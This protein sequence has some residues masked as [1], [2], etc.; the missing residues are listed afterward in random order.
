MVMRVSCMSRLTLAV[1]AV[2]LLG[3]FFCGVGHAALRGGCAKVNI[4]PPL[5]ITL[6]GSK[7]QPSDS[8]RDDLYARAMVLNDG[9][10]T[11]AVVSADLLYTPLEDIT[12]PVRAIV[13]EKSGIPGRN[14]MV[15]AIH[16]HSG[17]EV[18]SRSKLRPDSQVPVSPLAEAY[19]QVLV[20]KMADAV[21][22]AHAGMRDVKI[23]AATG[24]LPEVLYNRR[25]VTKAGRV[26]TTF[27]LPPEIAA[28]RKIETSPD[29][30]TRVVFTLP[31]E[32]T[33]LSFGIVDPQVFVL[34]MDDA[35][36]AIVGSLMGFGCHP[37][38][39][40]PSMSTT[41]SADYPAFATRVVEQAEGGIC[42]FTLGLAG[43]TVPL[44]RGAKPCAQI[45]TAL[46][47]EALRRLQ[48]VA[49]T[50]DVAVKAMNREVTLPVKKAASPQ[51]GA[52]DAS[53][54][55]V[56]TEIQV[57]RLGDIYLLGLPGE[58]LVE[59]GFA[60]RKQAGVEKLFIVTLANDAVGYIC[61][62]QAYEEGGYEV[63]SGTNLAQGAGEVIVEQALALINE[64]K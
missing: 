64:I 31:P 33:P 22:T 10:N 51:D 38:S 46:G 36:G 48:L 54:D 45:G 12:N 30:G 37:V 27:T 40:Y 9:A 61:H 11:V 17:P 56:T 58:V 53:P 21:L 35:G 7:G 44:Q 52:A 59:V 60:I 3:H 15:C 2:S 57:L 63:E 4:T 49:T 28:T 29:G 43:N 39:I 50:G 8:I 13:Q 19:R 62:Q 47:G 34:R 32:K 1:L 14:V 6:I 23:G 25:P 26:E 41:V 16:T 5:G 24:S 55:S 42:L 18:F 20:R